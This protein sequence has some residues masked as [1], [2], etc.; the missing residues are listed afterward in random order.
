MQETMKNKPFYILLLLLVITILPGCEKD[1]EWPFVFYPQMSVTSV[2]VYAINNVH[3]EA[4][5]TVDGDYEI[6]G[7]G[8]A[9]GLWENPVVNVS[10]ERFV[11]INKKP[12]KK[13][14]T[15]D[16]KYD[17]IVDQPYHVRAFLKSGNLYFYSNDVEFIV[18]SQGN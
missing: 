17:F 9:W 6:D 10:G 4:K 16:I 11:I 2:D 8:F 18:P 14:V 5:N 12:D 1:E 13:T 7:Y 3:F 15:A